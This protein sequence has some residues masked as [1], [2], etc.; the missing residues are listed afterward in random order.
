MDSEEAQILTNWGVEGINY[1]IVDGKRVMKE[2][3]RKRRN[4]DSDY[5]KETGVGLYAYPFPMWGNGA[6]DSNGQ[7]ITPDTQE[8]IIAEYTDAEKEVI[9]AYDM[10]SWTDWFPQPEEL[11]ISNHGRAFNYSIPS[12][13]DLE[14]IQQKADELVEQKITQAI[15]GDPEDFDA[16]W[17]EI[18]QDLI[19]LN[20]EKANEEMT[21]M[22]QD[23]M[24]LWGTK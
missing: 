16:A 11:G 19:D 1:D 17:E 4:S 20:I 22:D 13:S 15:L 21:K 10:E 6:V 5:A 9:S 14:I 3:D 7:S 12:G 18:Q 24:E 23:T 8:D 2:E